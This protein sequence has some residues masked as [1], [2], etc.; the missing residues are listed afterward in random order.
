MSRRLL[1]GRAFVGGRLRDGV[2]IE[3]GDGRIAAVYLEGE[4]PPEAEPFAGTLVPG[5]VD[6]HVHGAAG[7]DF[8][9]GS[10][11]AARAVAAFHAGHGTTALAATTLSAPREATQEALAAAA[12][13]AR[14]PGAAE[15]AIVGVHLEGPYLNPR[16]AGAQD[17]AALRAADRGEVA[18]WLGAAGA[19]PVLMTVA[20]EVP[21]VLALIAGLGERVIFSVGH[22]E[23]T[24]EQAERAFAAGARH[25]THL[26]NAMP[27]LHHRQP[28]PVAAAIAAEG[29][30]AELIADGV[31]VHP[32]MLRLALDLFPKRLLLITDAMRACGLGDGA[33]R[34]GALAVEVRGGEARLADGTLAGS[35]LTMARAV[36]FMVT[37]AGVPLERVLPMTSTAPARVLGLTDRGRIEAGCIADLVELSSELA[38]TRVLV[39]GREV[40][41]ASAGGW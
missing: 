17:P 41:R 21:G 29:V 26:F 11:Q 12:A 9:D 4:S 19:L 13:V 25:L 27:G 18:Q 30:T 33:Y 28:G 7:A 31:H 2:G 3:I 5:F 15:A 34:L 8:M 16:R 14:Q 32:A 23:A 1:Y 22:T 36:H 35:L 39:R 6:L 37:R 24:L 10:E 40:A 38:V 20:P